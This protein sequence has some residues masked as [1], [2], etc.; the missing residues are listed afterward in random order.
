[1]IKVNRYRSMNPTLSLNELI[2]FITESEW[3]FSSG[4]VLD[5][6]GLS[7]YILNVTSLNMFVGEDQESELIEFI[8]NEEQLLVEEQVEALALRKDIFELLDTLSEREKNVLILRFGLKDNFPRTLEE[9]GLIFGVTRERIRQ[10]QEKALRKL[11]HPSR[12]NKIED[13]YE[14]R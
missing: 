11:R 1:V 6:L 14:V 12:K 5:C 2:T 9:V 3:E 7:E 13:F 8:K 4:E 10:I